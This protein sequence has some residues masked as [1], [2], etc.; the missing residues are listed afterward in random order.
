[1]EEID[2]LRENK[3]K[4]K[5]LLLR[6]EKTCNEPS[7]EISLF[8]VKLEEVK[9]IEDILKKKL[10]EAE[11]KGEKLEVEVVTVRKYL[12]KFQSLYHENLTSIK[13]LE[14]LA[15][16]WNQQRNSKLKYSLGYE[17]VSSS[18]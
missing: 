7:K 9:N 2:R 11:T 13:G 3:R 16:I 17:E 8:K 4:Q 5:Q 18:G 1:M 6:Y 10:K 15:S 12:E 14:G